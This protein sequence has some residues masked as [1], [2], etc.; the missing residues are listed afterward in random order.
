M[1]LKGERRQCLHLYHYWIDP[2]FGFMNASLQTWFPF[3]IQ[4]CLN[5]REWLARQMDRVA[6]GMCVRA[7]VFLGWKTLPPPNNC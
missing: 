6:L 1:K 4:V 3:H 7:T 2:E 5:G